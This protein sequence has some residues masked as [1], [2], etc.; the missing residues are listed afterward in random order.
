[1]YI[2]IEGQFGEINSPYK[3]QFNRFSETL[4]LFT[5]AIK[6]YLLYFFYMFHF[7]IILN[8]KTLMSS[9]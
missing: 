6:T 5:S 9:Y 4:Q 1:M 8:Y 7:Y 3:M 2:R